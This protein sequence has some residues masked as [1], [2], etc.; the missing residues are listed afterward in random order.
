MK[1]LRA[2]LLATLI[3][4]RELESP[5]A[6]A[7]DYSPAGQP[8]TW[9]ARDHLA[10]VA[11]YRDYGATVLD[12]ARTGA[13]EPKDSKTGLDRRNARLLAENRKL[14]AGEVVDWA[15]RSYGRL[16]RAVEKCPD[17]V[18]LRPRWAGSEVPVWWLVSGC[19][20]GHVGQHLAHWYRDSNDWPA[21]ERIARQVHE[22]ERSSFEDVRYRAVATYN[23]GCFYA[24]NGRRDEALRL[25]EEALGQACTLW[26]AA[27][28]DPDLV[29][30]RHLLVL[31]S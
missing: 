5:L 10:H 6:V 14:A 9:T 2:S 4:S 21:A 15:V 17:D 29:A 28:R 23:L 19:G 30:I 24:T 12:A 13:A 31:D 26:E 16:L 3:N 27:Q 1:A 25:V 11:H 20:W 7:C 8:G 22:I 18:L